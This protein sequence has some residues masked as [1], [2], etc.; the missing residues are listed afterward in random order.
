MR[1]ISAQAGATNI[2]LHPWRANAAPKIDIK[3]V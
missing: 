2:D 1:I 3:L